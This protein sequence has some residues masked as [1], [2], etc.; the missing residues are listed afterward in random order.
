MLSVAAMF[1]LLCLTSNT[2]TPSLLIVFYN[3]FTDEIY[4]L[5]HSLLK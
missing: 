4:S 2:V 3:T 5:I 1:V